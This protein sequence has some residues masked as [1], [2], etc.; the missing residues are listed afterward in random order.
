MHTLTL[1]VNRRILRKKLRTNTKGKVVSHLFFN[2]QLC[3]SRKYKLFP[4]S[5]LLCSK[6]CITLFQHILSIIC[7]HW[8]LCLFSPHFHSK[9]RLLSHFN[10]LIYGSVWAFD[11]SHMLFAAWIPEE[12]VMS[13]ALRFLHLMTVRVILPA[14]GR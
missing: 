2:F 14:V 9:C 11:V 8:P 10:S 6:I 4:F 12:P 1:Q 5:H 7:S 3:S 13:M